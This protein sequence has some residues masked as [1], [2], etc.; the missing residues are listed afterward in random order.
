VNAVPFTTLI[1]IR[2]RHSQP[3]HSCGF[4]SV[5]LAIDFNLSEFFFSFSFLRT[6]GL[7]GFTMSSKSTDSSKRQAR[8]SG[9]LSRRVF[10]VKS[11]T[12]E[13]EGSGFD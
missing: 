5:L 11:V 3:L 4:T 7:G 8:C 9:R 13:S 6:Q 10:E 2:K 12:A 1:S